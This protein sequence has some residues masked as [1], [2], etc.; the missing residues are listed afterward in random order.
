MLLC[1]P[2][3][4]REQ[5][6]VSI[7]RPGLSCPREQVRIGGYL[8]LTD[9]PD[10]YQLRKVGLPLA[11]GALASLLMCWLH[12]HCAVVWASRPQLASMLPP[13]PA[14]VALRVP[15]QVVETLVHPHYVTGYVDN[16]SNN[17]IA[18]LLLDKP[19]T[20]EPVALPT[21]K[22]EW[23]RGVGAWLLLRGWCAARSQAGCWQGSGQGHKSLQLDTLFATACSARDRS[24]GCCLHRMLAAKPELP[25]PKNTQLFAAG[26]GWTDALVPSE[27]E[28]LQQV[29]P[30]GGAALLLCRLHAVPCS[31]VSPA[32]PPT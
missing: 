5:R 2:V 10:A 14:A 29:G 6:S 24:V 13:P 1:W 23:P 17:D 3:V 16:N 22:R 7:H 20:K 12:F 8:R 30:A 15:L 31:P 32:H 18:L 21:F 25:W 28:R 27:A 9:R 4:G 11:V 19:S 26:W